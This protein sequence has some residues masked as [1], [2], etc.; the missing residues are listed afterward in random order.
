MDVRDAAAVV[1]AAGSGISGAAGA[2][3]EEIDN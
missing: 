1:D 3:A 2:G